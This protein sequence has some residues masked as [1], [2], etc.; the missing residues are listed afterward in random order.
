MKQALLMLTAVALMA[1]GC[2]KTTDTS[3][4]GVEITTTGLTDKTSISIDVINKSLSNVNILSL[5]NQF[6]N[7]T[8]TSGP[9]SRGNVISIT[10]RSNYDSDAQNNGV[11]TI[12]MGYNGKSIASHGGAINKA[13][14]EQTIT[15]PQQ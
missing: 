12:V 6:G 4:H 10:I 15:I 1:T 9:V 8:Y 13:G 14:F 5:Q 7:K 11:G 2:K 3:L